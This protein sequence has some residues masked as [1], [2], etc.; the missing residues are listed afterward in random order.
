[1]MQRGWPPHE[2][3]GITWASHNGFSYLATN[4]LKRGAAKAPLAGLRCLPMRQ[5]EMGA[6]N[7]GTVAATGRGNHGLVLSYAPVN[8]TT[9]APRAHTL[10]TTPAPHTAPCR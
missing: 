7:L 6:F 1:M 4:S 3:A 2:H 5:F 8:A 10:G 9:I